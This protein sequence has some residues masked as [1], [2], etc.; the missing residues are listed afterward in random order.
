MDLQRLIARADE[1]LLERS[2]TKTGKLKLQAA[3]AKMDELLA[4]VEQTAPAGQVAKHQRAVERFHALLNSSSGHVA[5][6]SAMRLAVCGGDLSAQQQMAH[7]GASARA[8]AAQRTQAKEELLETS[9]EERGRVKWEAFATAKAELLRSS[10]DGGEERRTADLIAF[11]KEEQDRLAE[12]IM[13]GSTLMKSAASAI[14]ETLTGDTD[15]L[16][17]V[18]YLTNENWIKVAHEGARITKQVG[19]TCSFTLTTIVVCVVVLIVF[20]WMVF[21]IRL[22]GK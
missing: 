15:R 13:A 10:A 1:H 11:H 3:V 5:V 8:M 20:V 2:N 22:S 14:Q 19:R 7:V 17:E 18:S 4:T 6:S 12:D 21:L 16:K 9:E